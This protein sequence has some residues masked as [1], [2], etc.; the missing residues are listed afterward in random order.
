LEKVK[1]QIFS[2]MVVRFMVMN[3]MIESVKITLN[4]QKIR[5]NTPPET[6]IA[7]ENG[8]LGDYIL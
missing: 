2:E 6:N 1:Q 7:P 3:P 4:K 8:W 5:N